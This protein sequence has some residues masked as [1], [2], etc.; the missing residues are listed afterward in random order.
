MELIY[1][2]SKI[3]EISPGFLSCTNYFCEIEFENRPK[4]YT[5]EYSKYNQSSGITT[6]H[7]GPSGSV[8]ETTDITALIKG[9]TYS[10]NAYRFTF[11]Y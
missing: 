9:Y 6:I 1:I 4:K 5:S 3:S 10:D 2:K 7:N 11:T 8:T